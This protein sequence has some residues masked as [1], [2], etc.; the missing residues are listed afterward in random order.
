MSAAV[1]LLLAASLNAQAAA[2]LLLWPPAETCRSWKTYYDRT[3][4]HLA[5]VGEFVPSAERRLQVRLDQ[6]ECERLGRCWELLADAHACQS[7]GAGTCALL[8]VGS[9]RLMVGGNCREV[10]PPR[11]VR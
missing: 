11:W 8:K 4:Q 9:V 7:H 5:E 10:P 1:V 6:W 3:H 2:E